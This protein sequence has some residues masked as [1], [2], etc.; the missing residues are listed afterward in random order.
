MAKDIYVEEGRKM[1]SIGAMEQ[2]ESI[3][4][5]KPTIDAETGELVYE[6]DL[7]QA[8]FDVAVDVGPS[9]T[10][11]RESTVRSLT[12]M[13]QVTSDPETQMI[14]QSMAIMNM[15]GE[16]I[17]DIKDFFRKKLVQMGVVP[18]T[19]E[20]QQQMMEAMMAQQQQ[21]DPQTVYLMAEAQK[22]EALARKALADTEL[23][24]A[25]AEKAKADTLSIL[26]EID[27][28]TK[29]TRTEVK[30][31]EV[32]PIKQERERLDIES[33]RFDLAIKMRQLEE[34]E[35]KVDTVKAQITAAQSLSEASQNI[36][37]AVSGIDSGVAGFKDAVEIMTKNQR[38][39]AQAAIK[40]VNRPKKLIREKGKIVGIE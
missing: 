28:P 22:S 13:M 21:Q 24:M 36:T 12:G 14:L 10:S 16:G 7:S 33:K 40:A 29:N 18:P 26:S 32:D 3:E 37:N 20:E 6:N 38:E 23:T 17:S 39:A 1:K 25:N 31:E 5:M 11:R 9:F 35:S 27:N 15:D 34:I 4:M 19:D 8:N 2:V 30:V